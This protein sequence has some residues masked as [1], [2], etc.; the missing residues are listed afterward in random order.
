MI[1]APEP[2][3][4]GTYGTIACLGVFPEYR[5]RGVATMLI[6]DALRLFKMHG[7]RY[8]YVGTP[9]RNIKAIRLY[10]KLGFE[11][12]FRIHLYEREI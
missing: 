11:P 8:A 7:C 12:I 5:R 2:G 3:S 4:R 6:V 1:R 9:E 10:E